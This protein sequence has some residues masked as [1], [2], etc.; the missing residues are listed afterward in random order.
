MF[1]NELVAFLDFIRIFFKKCTSF[2]LKEKFHISKYAFAMLPNLSVRGLKTA[3][4]G[5]IIS[6]LKLLV[7]FSMCIFVSSR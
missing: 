5:S 6:N 7:G 2:D 1:L 4:N 3:K